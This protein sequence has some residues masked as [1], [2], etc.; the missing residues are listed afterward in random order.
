MRSKWVGMS[1]V[2]ALMAA[3]VAAPALAGSYE[4]CE[5]PTQECLDYMATKMKNSGWVGVE[6]E[7][8]EAT[9]GYL[10]EKVVVGS[11][12]EASGLSQGDIVVAVNGVRNTDGEGEAMWTAHKKVKAGDAVTWTVIRR[13]QEKDISITLAPMPADMLAKVIGEHMMQ[14]ATVEVAEA[15]AAD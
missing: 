9:S 12:A 8:D 2:A 3:L 4:R 13:G 6:L 7:M 11:P 15:E 10:L 1:V 14:H 5:H